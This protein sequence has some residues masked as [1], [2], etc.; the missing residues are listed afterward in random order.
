D[1]R[2]RGDRKRAQMATQADGQFKRAEE[3]LQQGDFAGAE[4]FLKR[5]VEL[6]PEDPEFH[7]ALGWATYQNG[8]SSRARRFSGAIKHLLKSL[9]LS[10]RS[11]RAHLALGRIY[12]AEGQKDEALRHYQQEL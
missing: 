11:E 7:A 12:E 4:V 9:E 3:L 8:Q 5:A 1:Q 2:A 6:F 10:P